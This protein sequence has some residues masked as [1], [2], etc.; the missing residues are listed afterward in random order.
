MFNPS[1]SH[2]RPC[3]AGIGLPILLRVSAAKRES[4]LFSSLLA[5]APELQRGTLQCR[6]HGLRST[7]HHNS[8]TQNEPQKP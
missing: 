8:E 7:D 2:A 3:A 5:V 1:E 6:A 4:R